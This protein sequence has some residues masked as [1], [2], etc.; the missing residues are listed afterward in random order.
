MA[1]AADRQC[2]SALGEAKARELELKRREGSGRAG[3]PINDA[4]TP[5]PCR[6]WG[7]ATRRG[8]GAG[9]TL[10]AVTPV[11][12]PLR[13]QVGA[14]V[15]EDV[16]GGSVRRESLARFERLIWKEWRLSEVAVE[17]IEDSGVA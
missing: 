3:P 15:P 5:A 17:P 6:D 9:I 7:H 11:R 16:R 12:L 8:R 10:E 14:R 2:N 4:A 13:A 1:S